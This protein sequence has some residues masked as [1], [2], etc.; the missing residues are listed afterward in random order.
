MSPAGSPGYPTPLRFG[1]K[2]LPGFAFLPAWIP[3][4]CSFLSFASW[5]PLF[6]MNSFVCFDNP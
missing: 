4:S 3:L 6:F 2:A 1:L 5:I